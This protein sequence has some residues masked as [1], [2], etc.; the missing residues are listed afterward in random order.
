MPKIPRTQPS[1]RRKPFRVWL[2]LLI[3]L[4][5]AV[6]LYLLLPA[7]KQAFPSERARVAPETIFA[8]APAPVTVATLDAQALDSLTVAHAD[9]E[10]YTLVQRDGALHLTQGDALSA[11]S[12][13]LSERMLSAISNIVMLETVARDRAEVEE[14]FADM[15]L[16]PP[17]ITAT[18]RWSDGS[19][20]TLSFGAQLP[21]SAAY[22]CL[23]SGDRCVYLC[24]ASAYQAFEY[25]AG[26]LLPVTQPSLRAPLIDR[27]TITRRGGETLSMRFSTDSNGSVTGT[28]ESPLPYPMD[29]A[30]AARVVSALESF[31]LGAVQPALADDAAD[32]YGFDDPL[33]VVEAHQQA[34]AYTAVNDDGQLVSRD[35]PE[36]TLR[37]TF[38]RSEGDFFYTCHYEGVCYL[39]NSFLVA[40]FISADKASLLTRAPA[41][42][43][44]ALVTAVD[45]SMGDRVYALRYTRAERVLPNNQLETDER[46]N[47]VYDVSATLNGESISPDSYLA[48][49]ERLRAMRVSGELAEPFDPGATAP[50]WELVL[51]VRGGERRVVA[52]YPLNA[53]FD[54]I[55]VNGVAC[56]ELNVEAMQIALAELL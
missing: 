2:P 17:R 39:V 8:S 38:G 40:Q 3:A 33:A 48:F 13:V 42:M 6:A 12:D 24:D 26:M 34:G 41:D 14:H 46:G 27:V 35:A 47:V 36:T 23:W 5:L 25:T 4:A 22:Y 55:A 56:H 54:A 1:G 49:V 11:I 7:I 15:G 21:D 53:F 20:T 18:A 31:R 32:F 50:R 16:A 19:E 29:S 51:T 52:A 10:S 28:L 44:D 37:L 30:A 45:L 43:G 9:G